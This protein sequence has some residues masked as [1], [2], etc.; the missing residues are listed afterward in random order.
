MA[1]NA[2]TKKHGVH[3]MGSHEVAIADTYDFAGSD[4]NLEAMAY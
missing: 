3:S 2:M 4:P 1:L